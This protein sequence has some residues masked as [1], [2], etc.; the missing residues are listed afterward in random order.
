MK[1]SVP[2]TLTASTETEATPASVNTTTR[3]TAKLAHVSSPGKD[4]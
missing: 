4:A 1:Q 3:E 2:P